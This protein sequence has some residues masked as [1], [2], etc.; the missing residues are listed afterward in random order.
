MRNSTKLLS[1][2]LTD[3]KDQMLHDAQPGHE[4]LHLRD[5]FRQSRAVFDISTEQGQ[6]AWR[7]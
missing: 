5:D 3:H 2:N 7:G 4:D 1:I 6:C